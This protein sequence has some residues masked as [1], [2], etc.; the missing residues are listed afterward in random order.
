MNIRWMNK[1]M[2]TYIALSITL[3]GFASA[4]ELEWKGRDDGWFEVASNWKIANPE[5]QATQK[6]GNGDTVTIGENKSVKL[7]NNGENHVFDDLTL[8]VGESST[9]QIDGTFKY[10]F[11]NSTIT[12][13]KGA[14]FITNGT[15]TDGQNG[16]TASSTTFTIEDA[17][18]L[19]MR[20]STDPKVGYD[21]TIFNVKGANGLAL[22][23]TWCD[24]DGKKHYNFNLYQNGSVSI[25]QM[26]NVTN[27]NL[28]LTLTGSVDTGVAAGV[29]DIDASDIRMMERTLITFGDFNAGSIA[30]ETELTNL[31]NNCVFTSLD[32]TA[33]TPD[34]TLSGKEVFTSDDLGKYNLI[35]RAG[36]SYTTVENG[37]STTYNPGSLILQYTTLDAPEPTT[38]TLSLLALAGLAAYR[39]RK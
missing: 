25:A 37:I 27:S 6:P 11:T 16:F 9:L 31:F 35:Y 21:N 28:R 29:S 34:A 7:G 22:G 14:K 2:K 18:Q 24:T 32:K 10:T 17:A 3:V 12:L 26:N 33:L 38:A 20:N 30:P 5:T 13:E 39:R 8:T 36:T 19:D 4:T 23:N 15:K 1:G